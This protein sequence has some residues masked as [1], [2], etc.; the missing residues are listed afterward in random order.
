[1][2]IYG[3][4]REERLWNVVEQIAE[5][6]TCMSKENRDEEMH[7]NNGSYSNSLQGEKTFG[8][9]GSI[10]AASTLAQITQRFV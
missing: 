10:P 6:V 9:A 1:M 8:D 7:T 4:V 3:R 5:H 2:N